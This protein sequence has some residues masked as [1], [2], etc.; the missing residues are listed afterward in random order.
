MQ[1]IK[2]VIGIWNICNLVSY[3][4]FSTEQNL[5][6]I[7]FKVF[8]MFCT[9]EYYLDYFKCNVNDLFNADKAYFSIITDSNQLGN[10]GTES[11]WCYNVTTLL[12]GPIIWQFQFLEH[13]WRL[14]ASR[15]YIEIT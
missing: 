5:T 4:I 7:Q 14:A 11:F 2:L 6:K 1:H 9:S 15:L 3:E 8:S 13:I 12:A 10:N